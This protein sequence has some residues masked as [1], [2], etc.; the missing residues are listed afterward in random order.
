MY[1][2]SSM[3]THAGVL[4]VAT[5]TL[6][7]IASPGGS[8]GS[9]VIELA[10][11]GPTSPQHERPALVLVHGLDSTRHTWTTFIKATEGQW[12]VLAVDQRG[13]G[14]SDL[15]AE[16]EFSIDAMVADLRHTVQQHNLL[17]GGKKVVLVGHSMGGRIAMAYAAAH[18]EDL[19]AVVIED[20]DIKPRNVPS[21]TGTELAKR[22]AFSRAFSTWDAAA[23]VLGGFGYDGTRVD[24]WKVDGRVFKRDDGTWW[25]VRSRGGVGAPLTISDLSVR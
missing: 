6:A 10:A 2:T 14:E 19:H 4:I 23:D 9:S 22:R 15:G 17:N 13:H 8:S 20:M 12:N 18:P 7:R 3:L 5:T 21:I 1:G 11:T 24:G 16:E 25:S